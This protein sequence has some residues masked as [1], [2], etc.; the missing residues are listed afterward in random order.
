MIIPQQVGVGVSAGV[1]GGGVAEAML[2]CA[3]LTGFNQD[4]NLRVDT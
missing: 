4:W 2:G 3:K 1:G